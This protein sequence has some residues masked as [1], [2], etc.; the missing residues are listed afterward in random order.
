MPDVD[1]QKV[2]VVLED[3][4]GGEATL[5]TNGDS[6]QQM[7]DNLLENAVKFTEEGQITLRIAK[8]EPDQKNML[9]TVED[10]GCGIPKDR[11][12]NIFD[13]WVKIDE[14][15]EGLGLGLAYCRETAQKLGGT[16]TLD[17]TSEAG[18]AFTLSLPIETKKQDKK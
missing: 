18:T 1:P 7:L 6:L 17:K 12:V 16:L 14:F 2:K 15:K 9:F 8:D 13:R 4:T 10:T 3:K 5:Y 11:I